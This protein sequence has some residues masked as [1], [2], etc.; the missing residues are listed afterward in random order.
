MAEQYADTTIKDLVNPLAPA[1]LKIS[2]ICHYS[3]AA[4]ISKISDIPCFPAWGP[5]HRL[6]LEF[7]PFLLTKNAT[8]SIAAWS[9]VSI[10]C[11]LRRHAMVPGEMPTGFPA[12]RRCS[13]EGGHTSWTCRCGGTVANPPAGEWRLPDA[14]K[15]TIRLSR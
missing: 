3:A 13:P 4:L 8:A 7:S 10:A 11:A 15:R 14:G 2:R 12:V 5:P 1:L 9:A 6:R